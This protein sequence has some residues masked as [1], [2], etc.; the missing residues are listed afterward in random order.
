MSL[1]I[2][3]LAEFAAEKKLE[4]GEWYELRIRLHPKADGTVDVVLAPLVIRL[5]QADIEVMKGLLAGGRLP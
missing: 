1:K 3:G 4:T 2:D 5:S